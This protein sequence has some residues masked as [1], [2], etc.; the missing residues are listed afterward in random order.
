MACKA[1][2]FNTI[3]YYKRESGGKAFGCRKKIAILMRLL[4]YFSHVFATV[5]RTIAK[6]WRSS[7]KLKLRFPST[8]SPLLAGQMA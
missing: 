2:R 4:D 5:E 3:V 6:I 7:E 1:N 8:P